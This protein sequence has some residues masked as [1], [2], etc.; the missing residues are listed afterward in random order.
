MHDATSPPPG[1]TRTDQG[2]APWTV[3]WRAHRARD[4][5]AERPAPRGV[6]FRLGSDTDSGTD[7]DA[8]VGPNAMDG[9][10]VLIDGRP[11]EAL[12]DGPD[13]RHVIVPYAGVREPLRTAVQA[14]PHLALH[15]SHDNARFVAQHLVAMLV[16]L[17]ATPATI[18]LLDR[19]AFAA[20]RTG[21]LLVNVGRGPVIDENALYEALEAGRLAGVGLDVWWR[22]PEDRDARAATLP[23]HRPLHVHPDVLLSPHRADGVA[24]SEEACVDDVLATVDAIVSGVDPKRNRV[25][26]SAGY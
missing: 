24:T 25:D 6:Q 4:R 26:V 19:E 5:V 23:S 22:Y 3:W 11:S 13:L 8:D 18:G 20:M 16:S 1:C 12:L 10:H 7:A 14:R 2:D 15:N 21:T 9:V 17:P